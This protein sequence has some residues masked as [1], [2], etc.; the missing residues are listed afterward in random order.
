M[1]VCVYPTFPSDVET[2]LISDLHELTDSIKLEGDHLAVTSLEDD[3]FT[4]ADSPR[5][6]CSAGAESLLGVDVDG[7]RTCVGHTALLEPSDCAVKPVDGPASR[8]RNT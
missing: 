1:S 2:E 8:Q 4:E 7:A 5:G 6:A 3:S